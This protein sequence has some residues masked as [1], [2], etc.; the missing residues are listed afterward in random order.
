MESEKLQKRLYSLGD[1]FRWVWIVIAAIL[2]IYGL[3]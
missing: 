1:F 3:L 2:L